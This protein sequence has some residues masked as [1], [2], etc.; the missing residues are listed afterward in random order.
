MKKNIVLVV[1]MH[2]FF[3]FKRHSCYTDE[4]YWKKVLEKNNERETERE[5]KKKK[6]NSLVIG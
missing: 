1:R 2:N 5:K 3:S 4:G 6:K